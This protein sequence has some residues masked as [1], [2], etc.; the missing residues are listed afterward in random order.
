MT[1]NQYERELPQFLAQAIVSNMLSSYRKW[2]GD[3]IYLPIDSKFPLEDYYRLE[4]AYEAGDRAAIETSR[5]ALLA[6]IKR[7]AKSIHSKYLNPPET[8]NFG[9]MF[10]Q[11]RDSTQRWCAI[12]LSLIAF[13]VR[14]NCCGRP[15]INLIS[16][17]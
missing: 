10:Y 11:P 3:Y 13:V 14:K 9:I 16:L 1:A 5:K 2:Q 7:F 8:T 4:D 12:R 17:A 6:A 15:I